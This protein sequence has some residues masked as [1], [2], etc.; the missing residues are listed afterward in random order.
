MVGGWTAPWLRTATSARSIA[1]LA[2]VFS[3]VSCV[4][5]FGSTEGTGSTSDSYVPWTYVADVAST[6]SSVPAVIAIEADSWSPV[7]HSLGAPDVVR[8]TNGFATSD[9]PELP[10][11]R[12]MELAL[13]PENAC[14]L[15][16]RIDALE[17]EPTMLGILV[18]YDAPDRYFAILI[19]EQ[20][21]IDALGR[22]G[23]SS[24]VHELGALDDPSVPEGW[25]MRATHAPD[26]TTLVRLADVELS[27]ASERS[28]RLGL[29]RAA[30]LGAERHASD[31]FLEV[32]SSSRS[33]ARSSGSSRIP[34]SDEP[35]IGE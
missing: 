15:E 16:A 20:G 35:A 9:E 33:S 28:P 5:S 32:R 22:D 1:W 11:E 4:D 10:E 7:W 6:H 3:S 31:P 24:S 26:G 34:P 12:A 13:A 23:E 8:P 21:R 17:G 14:E 25:R 19:D 18:G 2:L 27:V 30:R 29:L